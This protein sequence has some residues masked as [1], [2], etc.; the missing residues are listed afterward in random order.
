PVAR[1]LV[2]VEEDAVALFLPPLARG[3]LR[4]AALDLAGEREGGASDL[5]ERPSRGDADPDVDAARSARLRP[6]DEPHVV[7][8]LARD[9]RDVDDLAPRDPGDGIEI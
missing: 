7:E 2:V 6:A 9:L 4:R 5:I 8:H 3:D 1:V